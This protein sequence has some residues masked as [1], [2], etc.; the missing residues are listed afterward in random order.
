MSISR[1]KLAILAFSL[2]LII[3]ALSAVAMGLF[4]GAVLFTTDVDFTCH[5]GSEYAFV[6]SV[7]VD[8]NDGMD[9]GEAEAVARCLYEVD[10]NQTNYEVKSVQSNGDGTWT[11][12]LLW[13]SATPRANGELENHSHYY[14]VHVNATD[15]TVEYDRCY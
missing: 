2:T 4:G 6:F 12:F 11:V 13:G 10:M 8:L 9:S 1:N 7:K 3:G 14:N 15:R 5:E